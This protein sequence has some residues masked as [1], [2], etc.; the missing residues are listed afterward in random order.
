MYTYLLPF[1]ACAHG[2]LA[3]TPHNQGLTVQIWGRGSQITF[4]KGSQDLL[5]DIRSY[6]H[7]MLEIP[8]DQLAG[9][10]RVTVNM[11]EGGL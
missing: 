1:A 11:E 5:L 7:E 4:F 8:L 6:H 10:E 3:R 2:F 9:C